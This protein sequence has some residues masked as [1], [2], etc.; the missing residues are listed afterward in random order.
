MEKPVYSCRTLLFK[1]I[2]FSRISNKFLSSIKNMIF[3]CKYKNDNQGL[4]SKQNSCSRI[5]RS[6]MASM[7]SKD[8]YDRKK[9]LNY[10]LAQLTYQNI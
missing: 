7:F 1:N 6:K 5:R 10:T 9:T 2:Q 8:L 4:I 3:L